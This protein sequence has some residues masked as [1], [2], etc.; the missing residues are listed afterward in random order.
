MELLE[1]I[2]IVGITAYSLLAIFFLWVSQIPSSNSRIYFWLISIVCVLFGRLDL[3][4]LSGVLAPAQVQVIYAVLLS[5]EKVFL[6][7]GL[8][9]FINNKA[10]IAYINVFIKFSTF[11]IIT[12]LTLFY[13]YSASAAFLYFFSTSQALFLAFVAVIFIQNR[14]LWYLRRSD[15]LIAVISIYAI[16]WVTFPIA[17]N[18]P[19]W[20]TFGYLFGNTLNLIIYLSFAYIVIYHFQHRMILAEKSA[21]A[22]ADQAQ[23][24][25]QAKSDFLANMSHEIRT[26][27][28]GVLGMLELLK[29]DD[30]TKGQ[31]NR[32]DIA[33]SSGK[34]LLSVINDILDFSKIEAG[35]LSIEEIDF[36]LVNL[37]EE[38]TEVMNDSAQ[39][40]S[41]E[42]MLDTS[43]ISAKNVTADPLRIKQVILNLV[44]NAIKFTA[45]G[46]VLI[47]ASL[48]QSNE[49]T[50]LICSVSDTGIGI[51]D[52]KLD[53]IFT[54]FQQEDSST[55]R[56]FGGTG[57]GL[58]ISKHLCEIMGGTLR[59]SSK[60]G[61]GSLFT[62]TVPLS[63][64]QTDLPDTQTTSSKPLHI[65][66][67][68]GNDS[69]LQ[70][71][72]NL[73][74][75]LN[76]TT[77]TVNSVQK[78]IT[79]C[80]T[81]NPYNVAFISESMPDLSG[82]LFAAELK[83]LTYCKNMRIIIC[84]SS[85]QQDPKVHKHSSSIDQVITK[86]VVVSKILTSL[87]NLD[88]ENNHDEMTA[89]NTESEIPK[90]PEHT[91]IL[92]VEDNRV[93]QAVAS[94]MLQ[95]FN[96]KCDKANNG[97]EAITMLN[98]SSASSTPYTLIFMDCQMPVIDGYIAT[99]NIRKGD[100]T[101]IYINIPIIAMT[102]NAMTGDREKCIAS[103][104][105]DYMTKPLAKT[106]VLDMLKKWVVIE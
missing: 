31:L 46:D 26:P 40:K 84:T 24:G 65:L 78:A 45:H 21:L 60:K 97:E 89:L 77:T 47:R 15:V 33:L 58:S 34:S 22:L 12:L 36:S 11:T 44:S 37:L 30:L 105:N 16:H 81:E 57:L 79:L 72:N 35:E 83:K 29:Q 70:V 61:H 6:I 19:T 94:Q 100:C 4:F 92:L 27:M 71:M 23:Q 73:L 91:R 39:K 2:N 53:R 69:Y 20:L 3:Y 103:G 54:S 64:I 7:L 87:S 52:T 101:N 49:H 38:V 55:T 98:E 48:V 18:Y 10:Q 5:L 104:M 106:A 95:Y 66:V 82:L 32:V 50:H 68:D 96:L 43:E 88:Y 14:S 99:Q 67:V 13:F 59:V 93:N 51:E 8:I 41:L 63:V 75:S 1:V 86:P 28:N 17:I 9:Y 90:W 56:T 102:A 80:Q 85:N 25:S 62:M 74:S 42:L 76:F